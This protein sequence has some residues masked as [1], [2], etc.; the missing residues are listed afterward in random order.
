M[1]CINVDASSLIYAWQRWWYE[2]EGNA[3]DNTW[4]IVLRKSSKTSGCSAPCY[5]AA[6]AAWA[7]TWHWQ[8][9]VCGTLA[10]WV[11]NHSGLPDW[12]FWRQM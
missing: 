7:T 6:E 9:F 3:L 1:Q 4:Q 12:L 5:S 11:P 2:Q 10:S 8:Q